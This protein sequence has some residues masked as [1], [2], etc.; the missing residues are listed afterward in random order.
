M[1]EQLFNEISDWQKQTFG[2][3]TP[4][5]KLAH[6]AEELQELVSDL[7]NNNPDR[8]LEFADCFFLLFGAAHADGMS[9]QD[10]CAAIK[11]KFDINKARN[12]GKPDEHGVVKH[13][14]DNERQCCGRCDGTNDLCCPDNYIEVKKG[15]KCCSGQT[16]GYRCADCGNVV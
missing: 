16:E 11:E 10:I 8:R 15:K 13:I 1:T 7:K 9:Y 5:S 3:A 2:H 12:W 6:M 4:L 14:K